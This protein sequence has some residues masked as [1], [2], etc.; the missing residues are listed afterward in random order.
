MAAANSRRALLQ[1]LAGSAVLGATGCAELPPPPDQ[2]AIRPDSTAIDVHC[3]VFNARDLPIVGFVLDVVLEGKPLAQLALGPLV[4]TIALILDSSSWTAE[5]EL[6]ALK[7]GIVR[8]FMVRRTPVSETELVR[9]R[10]HDALRRLQ[11]PD[12]KARKIEA[13][14]NALLARRRAGGRLPRWIRAA[15]RL[16]S[17]VR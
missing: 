13:R 10:A 12:E 5:D 17:C 7:G 11:E 9:Q 4:T 8:P 3:H 16:A 2:P 14:V 6:A 1:L 15:T